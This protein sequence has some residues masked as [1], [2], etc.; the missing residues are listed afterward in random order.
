MPMIRPVHL[1]GLLWMVLLVATSAT[2]T[3]AFFWD[4]DSPLVTINSSELSADDYRSWWKEWREADTP[5]PATPDEFIDWMLLF[6]EARQMQLYE[7]PSYQRKVSVFLKVRALMMLKQDEIDGRIAMPEREQLQALYRQDYVPRYDLRMAA[8][9]TE[10]QAASVRSLVDEGVPMAEAVEQAGLSEVAE[11]VPSSGMMRPKRLPEPLLALAAGIAKGQVAG[12]VF[13]NQS[14][15]LV[16]LL[17]TD[18]GSE[19]DFAS[20]EDDLRR[21]ILKEEEYRLTAELIEHL[22]ARYEVHIDEQALEAVV[23]E[24]VAEEDAARAVITIGSTVVDARTLHQAVAKAVHKGRG[25]DAEDAFLTTRQRIVNDILAQ[26]LTSQ[27]ALARHYEQQPPFK[28]TFEF[29]CQHRLIKELEGTLIRPEVSVS[30]ADVRAYYEQNRDSY[31]RHGAPELAMV[32][33][34]ET[35]LAKRL[36]KRLAAGEDFSAVMQALVPGEV[37]VRTDPVEHLPPAVR[38]AVGR[39]APGQASGA[40]SDGEEIYFVKMIR[41]GEDSTM[42]LEMIADQIRLTLEKERFAEKRAQLLETLRAGSR[43]KINR[44]VWKSLQEDFLKEGERPS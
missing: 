15:Y 11:Q 21:K 30:E 6:Q 39:L 1:A 13:W 23:P 32:Q 35:E 38:E 25:A 26:T 8:L 12:P 16:E 7:N 36:E 4:D 17:G 18:E 22:K 9:P 44:R 41:S 19:E 43:I 37:P 24:G 33:T 34:R 2:G 5:Q 3:H 31:T 29:Y 40:I 20:L 27:E 28:S 42:P 10:E 14:W